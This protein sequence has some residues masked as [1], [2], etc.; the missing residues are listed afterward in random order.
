VVEAWDDQIIELVKKHTSIKKKTKE[1]KL[2]LTKVRKFEDKDKDLIIDQILSLYKTR[3]NIEFFKW[4]KL[5]LRVSINH[6][7]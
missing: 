3:F 4:R 2:F 7:Q 5:S 1:T 6:N